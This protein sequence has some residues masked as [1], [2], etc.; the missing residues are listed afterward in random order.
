MAE[1]FRG[2]TVRLRVK[3]VPGKIYQGRLEDVVEQTL[4]LGDL[5]VAVDGQ[6]GWNTNHQKIMVHGYDI[7]D[8]EVV[9]STTSLV[10]QNTSF[11]RPA[12]DLRPAQLPPSKAKQPKN[13]AQ[14]I[15]PAIM[16]YA[17]PTPKLATTPQDVSELSAPTTQIMSA[18]LTKP[19]ADI[20]LNEIPSDV[21]KDNQL[22]EEV[23]SGAGSAASRHKRH[24]RGK[25]RHRGGR[26]THERDE[27]DSPEVIRQPR[28]ENGWRT[29]P[30][31]DQASDSNNL[32]SSQAHH[33]TGRSSDRKPR[34]RRAKNSAAVQNGWATE[35]ATDVQEMG[36]FDFAENLSK[37]DKHAVFAQLKDED[38]TADEDRLVSF[39]RIKQAPQGT[40]GGKNLHPLENV[41][42]HK[43]IRRS[44][45]ELGSDPEDAFDLQGTM[46]AS[47]IL[48][49]NSSRSSARREALRRG[50]SAQ[51]EI[52]MHGN[53]SPL[54]TKPSRGITHGSPNLSSDRQSSTRHV[55]TS[56]LRYA[57]GE[58][59]CPIITPAHL[60]SFEAIAI[61]ELKY[62]SDMLI[63]SAGRNLASIILQTL[64]PGG[65]RLG[66]TNHNTKPVVVFLLGNNTTGARA[67][68][69]ARHL[70]ERGVRV[71][72]CTS[73]HVSLS[74]ASSPLS[75][76][77]H[78]FDDLLRAWPETA[79]YLKTLD[80][81]PE[82]IV[83]GLLGT[84]T[85]LTSLED[86]DYS[87]EPSIILE[88]IGWA[89]KS[90]ASVLSVDIPSGIDATTGAI[91]MRDGE[92]AEVRACLVVSFGMP[93]VGL[94]RA[95]EV[96]H[97]AGDSSEE[98]HIYV[99]D[100]G[101][102]AAARLNSKN[103]KTMRERE[104]VPIVHFGADW[105]VKVIYDPGG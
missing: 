63:E 84:E 86:E 57:I 43:S 56:C 68:T 64:N 99:V 70:F 49:R 79:A 45:N 69:A 54:T 55:P 83:D 2:L 58:N 20:A 36:E 23:E 94:L 22:Q 61:S 85:T 16:S 59:V 7:A 27:E 102:N 30:I 65:R 35:D 77:W 101:L 76:A 103:A 78:R 21:P 52:N 25:R 66:N 105:A 3:S 19:F 50:S 41:L 28:V 100:I 60:S 92:P 17:R 37:F 104:K 44:S 75:L 73:G 71:I 34:H 67:L 46:T 8:I 24:H 81:P 29:T 91:Q 39:N 38:T 15:D 93:L 72:A 96:R 51:K 31:L 89:N 98:W 33:G 26:T 95:L 1:A 14:F 6:S 62:T 32:H 13:Q 40:F 87:D 10:A 82:L 88:M 80:A 5:K 42:D 90:R 4:F 18:T 97:A 53:F 11:V 9:S 47:K 74:S 12:V 48:E